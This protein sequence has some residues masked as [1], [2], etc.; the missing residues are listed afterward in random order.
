MTELDTDRTPS[1]ARNGLGTAGF[2]LGLVGLVLS[3][4][5][6]IGVIAWPLVVLGLV[7]SGVGLARVRS[8]KATNRGLAIAGLVLSVLG[9]VICV[10]MAVA[11]TTA[12]EE[13]DEEA[14]RT[15]EITYRV[16]G[17]APEATVSYTTYG[18]SVSMATEDVTELPWEQTAETSGLLKGGSLSVTLGADGGSVECVVLV[19]GEQQ[20][21]ATAV[22]AFNTASCS[23]F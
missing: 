10:V 16:T 9:T 18:D 4:I 8:K 12:V 7:F 11:F 5:P 13:I 19:D 6:F 15:V 17:D 3:P 14:N 1:E 21:T 23:D 20:R 22:G 2:V